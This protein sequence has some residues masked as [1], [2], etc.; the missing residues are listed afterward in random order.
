MAGH[1]WWRFNNIVN[2]FKENPD[3]YQSIGLID[4]IN[5]KGEPSNNPSKAFSKS[6][7]AG[8]SDYDGAKAFDGN[9]NT[10]ANSAAAPFDSVIEWW[11]GYKFDVDVNVTS[12][13]LQTRQDMLIDFGQEWQ[14]ADLEYSDDGV[15]WFYDTTILPKVKALDKSVLTIKIVRLLD[16]NI[17]TQKPLVNLSIYSMDESGSFSG[18]VTQGKSGEPKLPLKAEVL[19]YDRMTNKLLQRTWSSDLGEYSFSGLDAAREYYAVTLHPNRTYNAAIQDGL[20]S[21][22]TI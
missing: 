11:I 5:D 10:F 14:S 2:R 16:I 21:G 9:P 19:L 13:R 18:L 7:Y 8:M 15:I 20:T 22:M 1:K 12:V 4:F 6:S 3:Q 17:N